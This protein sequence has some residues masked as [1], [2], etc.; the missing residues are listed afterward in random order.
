MKPITSILS[1]I[2]LAT[3]MV[4]QQSIASSAV[5]TVVKQT[6]GTTPAAKTVA[7]PAPKSA[8]K[9]ESK[10]APKSDPVPSIDELPI[11]VLDKNSNLEISFFIVER[12]DGQGK[13]HRFSA[14]KVSSSPDATLQGFSML[15]STILPEREIGDIAGMFKIGDELW[16]FASKSIALL[17][18]GRLLVSTRLSVKDKQ[19]GSTELISKEPFMTVKVIGN[20]EQNITDFIDVGVKIKATPTILPT[21]L[22][23]AQLKM[24]ISEVL[25]END[26]TRKTR[27]PVISFRTVDTTIDFR[28]GKLEQLCELTIQKTVDQESG[29]PYLRSIP[30]IG[31]FL[32]SHT[33]RQTVNTKLYIVAGVSAPREAQLKEYEALKKKVQEEVTKKMMNFH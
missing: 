17:N 13:S 6:A 15:I 14:N 32:F 8:P 10:P 16:A 29:I 24:S 33:S 23:Q 12:V 5:K 11:P 30:Y 25:R 4:G 21:G 19:V 28:P 22:V 27:V 20:R 31:K 9:A 1:F 3:L 2:M 26:N 18:N 7:A